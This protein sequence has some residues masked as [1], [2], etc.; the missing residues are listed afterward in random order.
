MYL[1]KLSVA[2]NIASYIFFFSVG[3]SSAWSLWYNSLQVIKVH[4]HL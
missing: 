2:L 4:N 3:L 1:K